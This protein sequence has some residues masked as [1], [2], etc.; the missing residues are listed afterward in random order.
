MS[1]NPV[2]FFGGPVLGAAF[3]A[4]CEGVDDLIAKNGIFRSLLKDIKSRLDT[5]KPLISEMAGSNQQLSYTNKDELKG[6]EEVFKDGEELVL[7]CSKVR[8]WDLYRKYKYATKLFRLEE[9]L[10]KSLEVLQVQG[11]RDG[12][13][14]AVLVDQMAKLV[15]QDHHYPSESK[16]W[17]AVPELPQLIVGLEAPL[18]ELKRKILDDGGASM[19][20]VTAPGGCGKTTLAT[21][22]CQDQQ[23]KGI[24]FLCRSSIYGLD[25]YICLVL[26]Q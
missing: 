12:K 15:I 24:V 20:V 4:L 18:E 25:F 19:I 26:R 17:C 6:L 1:I 7:K 9:Q 3:N 21:K 10:N 14:T 2:E 16:A 11:I 23:V 5:V 13:K 8:R 22:F